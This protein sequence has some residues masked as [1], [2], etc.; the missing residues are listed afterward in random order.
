[1]SCFLDLLL[2][3]GND[4]FGVFVESLKEDYPFLY[5]PLYEL[6]NGTV[7]NDHQG[8]DHYYYYAGDV[9]QMMKLTAEVSG[10]DSGRGGSG[11]EE[12]DGSDGCQW[13]GYSC[14]GYKNSTKR[15]P[16]QGMPYSHIPKPYPALIIK[17]VLVVKLPLAPPDITQNESPDID[18]TYDCTSWDFQEDA[19]NRSLGSMPVYDVLPT[20][21]RPLSVTEPDEDMNMFDWS[22]GLFSVTS[23]LSPSM[24]STTLLIN[25]VKCAFAAITKKLSIWSGIGIEAGDSKRCTDTACQTDLVSDT[26]MTVSSAIVGP[27][28]TWISNSNISLAI[29]PDD[30]TITSS[31]LCVSSSHEGNEDASNSYVRLQ[32]GDLVIV[33]PTRTDQEGHSQRVIAYDRSGQRLHVPAANLKRYDDPTGEKWYYPVKIS[34]EVAQLLL[35]GHQIGTFL[36]YQTLSPTCETKFNLSLCYGK[37]KC[38]HHHI[39]QDQDGSLGFKGKNTFLNVADLVAYYK[40]N[41]DCL[42]CRLRRPP[43]KH[44]FELDTLQQIPQEACIQKEDIEIISD[45]KLGRGYFAQVQLAQYRNE[46][47]AVKMLNLKDS[48]ERALEDLSDEAHLMLELEHKN[49][50]RCLGLSARSESTVDIVMELIPKG[51]VRRCVKDGRINPTDTEFMLRMIQDVLSALE[52][53]NSKQIIHRDVAGRNLLLDE[54]NVTKLADFGMARKVINDQYRA[55]E[56]E[57]IPVRWAAPEVLEVLLYSSRSDIWAAAISF[58]EIF[59]GGEKPYKEVSSALLTKQICEGSHPTKPENCP[60]RIFHMMTQCWRREP[61]KRPSASTLLTNLKCEQYYMAREVNRESS[62]ELCTDRDSYLGNVDLSELSLRALP[63]LPL[64]VQSDSL[65][66]RRTSDPFSE[67]V[68]H[69]KRHQI[70]NIF[71]RRGT[72]PNLQTSASKPKKG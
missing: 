16:K 10:H 14:P 50:V 63:L 31:M 30:P 64:D 7:K 57:S 53:L 35:T 44:N 66:I 28:S 18:V 34:K 11:K 22:N 48:S 47:V 21:K 27:N 65:V 40:T 9:L 56:H 46:K 36:V 26:S 41:R 71:R 17:D 60:P 4:A 19:H 43:G 32:K 24:I 3:R 39:Y 67:Q 68:G 15:R 55:E 25:A 61:T 1:M 45:V 38:T 2:K 8:N 58:W 62:G 20:L 54:N 59:S 5:E 42:P 52:Y 72:L 70:K 37:G 51:D 29:L 69:K 13:S 12:F 23:V 49:I 33:D 6:V